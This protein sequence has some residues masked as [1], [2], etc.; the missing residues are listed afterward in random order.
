M[1]YSIQRVD[2]LGPITVSPLTLFIMS[3]F[4][5]TVSSSLVPDQVGLSVGPDLVTI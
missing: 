1:I 4:I 5:V 2:I 3:N